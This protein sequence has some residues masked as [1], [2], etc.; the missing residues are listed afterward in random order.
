MSQLSRGAVAR[1][2][3]TRLANS[4]QRC[5]HHASGSDGPICVAKLNSGKGVGLFVAIQLYSLN[6]IR[7]PA[8]WYKIQKDSAIFG[9]ERKETEVLMYSLMLTFFHR[10]LMVQKLPENGEKRGI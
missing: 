2:L 1:S 4:K 6:N 5:P 9:K 10:S 8:K 7:P 3:L